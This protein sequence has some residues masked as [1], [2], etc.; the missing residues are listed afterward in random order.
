MKK[1]IAILSF[2]LVLQTASAQ[3][4]EIVLQ[5]EDIEIKSKWKENKAGE[6]ELRVKFKNVSKSALNVDAE[7]NFYEEGILSQSSMIN[8]CLKKGLFNNWFRNWHVIQAED[9]R[10][11][12]SYELKMGDV[13]TEK[14]AECLETEPDA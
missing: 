11:L 8:T 14:V 1:I 10:S 6:K 13:N 2:F 4:W 9:G 5:S 3:K 7:F 12:E